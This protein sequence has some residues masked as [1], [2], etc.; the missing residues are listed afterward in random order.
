M[1]G[2]KR[3]T[4]SGFTYQDLGMIPSGIHPFLAGYP[5]SVG[6]LVILMI[7][8]E[9]HCY[10]CL[11]REAVFYAAE[12]GFS[13]VK[14]QDC[15]LIYMQN[16]PSY[17]EMNEAHKQGKHKGLKE[18]N[19]TGVFQERKIPRYINVL[20]DLY[21]TLDG[22]ISS[23]L[24]VGCGHGE[25]IIA[26]DRFSKHTISIS[27]T[28]PNIYKQESARLRG[29]NVSYFELATHDRRYDAISLLNVYSHL[30]DP[31]VF[32]MTIKNLLNR[33]GEVIIE[34]GD[35]AE[36]N[37]EDHYRPFYLPNHVSFASEKIVTSILRRLGFRILE[38]KKYPY[39]N[40]KVPH[41]SFKQTL[42]ELPK[43]LLPRYHSAIPEYLHYFR[44]KRLYSQTDMYIRA[45]I[46]S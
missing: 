37:A 23:W 42:K 30:P 6:L 43:L 25:F 12:N 27:G 1:T 18:R 8:R 35:T 28:E 26:L 17:L 32:L 14:C 44:Y 31:P 2:A 29:M 5:L 38:I 21:G 3:F 7:N 39:P 16:T 33:K 9:M 24:D 19:V 41:F 11:S 15:G 22:N 45:K 20:N 4:T 10:N 46:E 36:L 13:L 40:L 34:T